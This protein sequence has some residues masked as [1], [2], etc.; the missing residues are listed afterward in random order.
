MKRACVLL[1]VV[2]MTVA[3]LPCE[4]AF[5]QQ[6]Q[7][8]QGGMKP[9]PQ[10]IQQSAKLNINTASKA[11]L[12]K[13]PGI[14]PAIAEKIVNYRQEHGAFKTIEDLKNVSGIGEK[15]F[16]MLKDLITVE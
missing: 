14:G 8:N 16:E 10:Q 11:D 7:G 2:A 9:Q 4:A 15:K 5:A 3:F 13:L 1:L 12:E 6:V